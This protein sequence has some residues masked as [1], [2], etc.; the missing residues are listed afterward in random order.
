MPI[1]NM[2]PQPM[3]ADPQGLVPPQGLG[4]GEQGGKTEKEI[5]AELIAQIPI[6][7]LMELAKDPE[8]LAQMLQQLG[9]QQGM[10]QEEATSMSITFMKVIFERIQ[11]E[12]GQ[13]IT[14]VTGQGGPTAPPSIH[15]NPQGVL[16]G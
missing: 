2:N 3:P 14:A 1:P 15:Q 8:K 10:S 16:G 11:E 13:P 6:E 9:M 12:T 5:M 7:Q 4:G